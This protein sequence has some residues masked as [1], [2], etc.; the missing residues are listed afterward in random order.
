MTEKQ[1]KMKAIREKMKALTEEQKQA[2]LSHGL[3]ATIEGRYLSPRNTMICY[4]QAGMNGGK[5]PTVVGGY[6]QMKAAGRQVIKGEHGYTIIF[7]AM[8]KNDDGEEEAERFMMA[9]V[10]DISQTEEMVLQPA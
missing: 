1:A 4:L 7:P 3:I 10:F 6:K 9:T 5:L 2:L 8:T